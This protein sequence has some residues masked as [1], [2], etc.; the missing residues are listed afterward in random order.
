MKNHSES[1]VQ[2]MKRTLFISKIKLILTISWSCYPINYINNIIITDQNLK[3]K[4]NLSVDITSLS[5]QLIQTTMWKF[6][7][8][9]SNKIKCYKYW[10]HTLQHINILLI[11]S[12]ANSDCMELCSPFRH[13]FHESVFSFLIIIYL[14]LLT[15]CALLSGLFT[16][17]RL[18]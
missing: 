14:Q 4:Y 1:L 13:C 3:I 16:K 7:N 9:V 10:N 15:N 12:S 17:V 2:K 11:K 18:Y 5:N 6:W 8:S